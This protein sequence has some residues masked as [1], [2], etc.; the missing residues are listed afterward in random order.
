MNR[1]LNKQRGEKAALVL[2]EKLC[3]RNRLELSQGAREDKEIQSQ[4]FVWIIR[5]HL[6]RSSNS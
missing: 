1:H 6:A 2:E 5:K 3:L 4:Q